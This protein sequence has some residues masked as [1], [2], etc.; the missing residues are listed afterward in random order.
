MEPEN[1]TSFLR[2]EGAGEMGNRK[3]QRGARASPEI[4]ARG[5]VR[6]V[7]GAGPVVEQVLHAN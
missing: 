6:K 1:K 2:G 5:H 3:K 4:G 7:G